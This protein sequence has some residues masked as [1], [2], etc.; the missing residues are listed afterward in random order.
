M[1]TEQVYKLSPHRTLYLHGFDRRGSAAALTGASAA[2]FTA[3]GVFS[4][5]A[6]FAVLMLYDADD[7]FGHLTTTK[8][9][10]DFDLSSVVL[11]FDVAA[12]NLQCPTSTKFQSVPWGALSY[13]E[14]TGSRGT[15]ALP[16]TATTGDVAATA[17]YTVNGTP[18]AFDRVQLIYLGN[19]VFDYIV[20]PGDTTAAIATNLAGQI[21]SAFG[22]GTVPFD[23]VA[24]GSTFTLT[25]GKKGTDGNSIELLELHKTGTTFLT[26]TGTG[27]LTGG[28]DPTSYHVRIDFTALGINSLRQAW[29][30]LAPRL[31]YDSGPTNPALVAY[32]AS[33]WSA[34]V[35]GWTV[36]D[37]ST[38]TPLSI[39][40]P[41]SVLTDS[42]NISVAYAGS[43]WV[44]DSG[45]F[46]HGFSY[47]S[48]NSGDT[49]TITYS[50]QST[51]DLQLGTYLLFGGGTFHVSLDGA[52]KP[53]RSTALEGSISS[54]SPFAGRRV[55]VA[56]VAAGTHTVK[57]TVASGTCYF[58][59]LQA[60][61]KSI[62]QD[63]P[64]TYSGVNGACD[65]DTDQTYKLSPARAVWTLQRAGFKG[66]IDFYAGVFFG[67][68]RLRVGGSFH[69][70]T[71]TISGTLGTGTGFGDGDAFFFNI[72]GTSFGAAAY[73][74]DTTTT[75]AQ[76]MVDAINATFVGVCAA[77]TT[78]GVFIVTSLSP[79]NGFAMT[80]SASSG[81]SGAIAMSGDINAGNEGVWGVDASQSSPINR[82]LADYLVDFAGVLQAAGQT[83]TVS[84]SQELLA[85]P[86]VN[87]SSGA[88]TQRFASGDS[89]LTDTAFGSWGAGFVEGIS[90]STVQWTGH[91]FITGNTVHIANSSGGGGVWAIT[92]TDANHFQ[93]TASI[94]NTGGYSPAIGDSGFIDLQTSQCCF[95]SA[96]VTP[97]MTSCYKQAAGILS[98]AGLTPWVQFGEV[99]WWFFGELDGLAVGFASFTS[100]ISI[101]TNAPHGRA[102]GQGAIIA[103]V[104]GN[105]AANGDWI[106]TVVDSTHFTLDGSSGNG[107]Y[108]SS[109]GTVS[110]GGMAY[111]D[112]NTA[113]GRSLG[114]WYT[115]DDN[116]SSGSFGDA[117]YLRGLLYTHMHSMAQ[118]I[119]AA[120]SSAKVEWLLPM[121]VNNPVVYWNQGYPFPQGGRLNNYVNI[122][123]QYM[124]TN[125]D[126]D[127]LKLEA[128]SWGLNY[129]NL[130]LASA[131]M[132]YGS[133][134]LAYPK[135][136]IAYL[137][138]WSVGAAAW[139][140]QY[141]AAVNADIP[142][143]GM[144]AVDHLILLSWDMPLPA[145]A[146]TAKTF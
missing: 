49:A 20:N 21:H 132:A 59:Y 31:N 80:V 100:P 144:W 120:Y 75:I 103:G 122:P 32:V 38:V 110:G 126:I 60:A 136:A 42:G 79:I 72:G 63:P 99:G 142:L 9:L 28:I 130:D 82:A 11:D 138:P 16:I 143:I 96:T 131:A 68:K 15:V 91:G 101:G 19:V 52:S 14:S 111:Y 76:R 30:T 78:A 29:L 47:G 46:Y 123:S 65:F 145:N 135:S 56:G 98:T 45:D 66:D 26:P 58:D 39:A 115:Q 141:L 90:G 62:V 8:Y 18:A 23:A 124:V 112:A 27:K 13:V 95:N 128:L 119:K 37:P 146:S 61:V 5:Q 43:G 36:T 73:P 44:E 22:S 140:K 89:V 53:D 92:V 69:Q 7:L 64:A 51:H 6:D 107:N 74:A 67:L 4:D 129:M 84:F 106:I 93:L 35:S 2:G 25:M 34:V 116:P 55:L 40:G 125:G 33:E 127:R 77:P 105:T 118:S 81:A 134:T 70:A 48:S 113:A 133:S 109:T 102:T 94:S 24:S 3:S 87:T 1:G 114:N 139:Q 50:C 71:V 83:M 10:P 54:D 117:N 97:Y 12:T 108:V 104:E 17:T 85:P 57:L 86:D 137:V 121:D 41:G 88:W